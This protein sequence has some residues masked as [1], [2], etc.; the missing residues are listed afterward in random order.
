MQRNDERNDRMLDSNDLSAAPGRAASS[1]DPTIEG[2]DRPRRTA[3]VAHR[4]DNPGDE[5]GE[6]VGGI[7]GVLTGAALGSLGGPIGTIIGG[8]AGAVTGWWAGKA[9]SEAASHVTHEDEEYYRTHYE[10]SPHRLADRTYDDVRPAYQ[11]GHL[12]GRNPDYQGR[13]F[14]DVET[15][16]Q[17]GWSSEVSA[18]HG[19]SPQDRH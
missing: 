18:R 9:I 2:N 16:I 8:I 17:R 10:R 6:A 15:D 7:S 4:D 12:A 1:A 14:E 5:I 3:D 11:L 13:S 19:D